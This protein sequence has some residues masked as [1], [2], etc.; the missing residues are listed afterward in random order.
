MNKIIYTVEK[1]VLILHKILKK[2]TNIM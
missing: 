1:F 2:G